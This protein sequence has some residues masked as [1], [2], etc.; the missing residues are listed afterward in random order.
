MIEF[1]L[2]PIQ[3]LLVRSPLSRHRIRPERPAAPSQELDHGQGVIT[4]LVLDPKPRPNAFQKMLGRLAGWTS[5]VPGG[6]SKETSCTRLYGH[7]MTRP[8]LAEPFQ[9][10]SVP[11]GNYDRNSVSIE[12]SCWQEAPGNRDAAFAIYEAGGVC[13]VRRGRPLG[14]F[15]DL[16]VVKA[17]HIR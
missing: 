7:N 14:H 11:I 2:D 10:G 16:R 4:L 12:T 9:Y 17:R 1:A 15:C 5:P 6:A 13:P 3:T 8:Q